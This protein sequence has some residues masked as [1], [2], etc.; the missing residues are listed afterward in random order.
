MLDRAENHDT[1]EW[2]T[3]IASDGEYYPIEKLEA[4]QRNVPH[5]AISV[6]VV[7]NGKL[8]LQQR[9]NHKYHSGGLWA[10]TCCSHPRWNERPEACAARRLPEEVGWNTE[11]TWFGT[12]DYVADVGSALFEN[13]F[14]HCFVGEL[15]DDSVLDQF[16][17]EEVQAVKW[18][19][20]NDLRD[21]VN[22]SP[23]QFTKW[24]RIYLQKHFQMIRTAAESCTAEQFA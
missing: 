15:H 14:A 23:A 8:L 13:E 7:R 21:E 22:R 19:D 9:A 16:N 6:F 24:L 4:H 17:P 12:I 2:I 10:N 18:V 11:L 3:A 20:L 5:L 1:S